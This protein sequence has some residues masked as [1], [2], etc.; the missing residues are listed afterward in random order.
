MYIHIHIRK[1]IPK[2]TYYMYTNLH[3]YKQVTYIYI[4]AHTHTH[5]NILDIAYHI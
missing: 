5:I 1:L 3:T 2:I 4:H